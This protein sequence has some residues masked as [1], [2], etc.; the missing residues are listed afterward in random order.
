MN[1]RSASGSVWTVP[2]AAFALA[3]VAGI[4]WFV[5]RPSPE[6]S[7]PTPVVVPSATAAA[8][9]AEF[10]FDADPSFPYA[11][12]QIDVLRENETL[13]MTAFAA[14][15]GAQT[16]ELG[17]Y[18]SGGAS[19]YW[20]GGDDE[21]VLALISGSARDVTSVEHGRVHTEYLDD[22]GL[23][24]VAVE[25]GRSERPEALVWTDEDGQLHDS[26]DSR[27]SSATVSAGIYAVTVFEDPGLD[28]WGY[29]DRGTGLWTTQPLDTEPVGTLRAIEGT[30]VSDG[31]GFT[32]AGWVGILPT[33]GTDP[34]LATS[35]GATWG[36]APLGETGRIA[37]AVFADSLSS[38]RRIVHSVAYT[39]LWGRP[40]A[41]RP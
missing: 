30:G 39:D 12:A 27:I 23:T 31:E 14:K 24:A 29:L 9:T 2:A 25:R 15:R 11:S 18:T 32:Q 1:P 13:T 35:E 20:A 38:G 10:R 26:L 5:I 21:I 16:V 36:S 34:H 6:S 7:A 37:I 17:S 4:S 33:G 41:Y 3:L 28:V 22:I 19:I 8:A 40:Q